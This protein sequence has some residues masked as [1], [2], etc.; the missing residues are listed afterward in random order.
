LAEGFK[1]MTQ[2]V[3]LDPHLDLVATAVNEDL[4]IRP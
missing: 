1:N 3:V 4:G 2:G